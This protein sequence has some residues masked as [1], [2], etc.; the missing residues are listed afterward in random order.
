MTM[1]T[2]APDSLIQTTGGCAPVCA[3]PAPMPACRPPCAAP[4]FA[5]MYYAPMRP[6]YAV[7]PGWGWSGYS[8]AGGWWP[9]R[10][11]ARWQPFYR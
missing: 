11:Q 2:L 9:G 8:A 3:V 10:A 5:P 4:G 6:Q 1:E 7:S